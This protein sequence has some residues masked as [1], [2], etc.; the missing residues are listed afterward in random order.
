MLISVFTPCHK[1]NT[2]RLPDLYES[3]KAQ[4]HTDRQWVILLNNWAERECDDPRVKIVK[5]EYEGP[6]AG[7]I[8][9][10][11]FENCKQCDG[12]RFVEVD[13][14]DILT[15]DCLEE[16]AKV[17]EE[18]CFAY[19]NTVNISWPVIKPVTRWNY[20]WRTGRPFKFMDTDVVEMRSAE[21]YP[22][23]ISRIW[24]APNHPRAWRKD[25]YFAIGWHNP[26]MHISDDHDLIQ[27]T[28]I[29]GKLYHIDKPLYIYRIRWDNT[30]Q[31]NAK[32]IQDTMREVHDKFFEP[33]MEKRSKENGLRLIDLWGWLNCKK[34]Y[35]SYDIRDNADIVGD[36]N[37]DRNLADNSVGYMNCSHVLEHLKDRIHSMNEAYRVLAHGW[38][39]QI[40]V[41]SDCWI[42]VKWKYYAP[43]GAT[44]DP[45]HVSYR[46]RR[47]FRYFTEKAMRIFIE[48]DFK[49]MFTI[50]KP[51]KEFLRFDDVPVCRI[52]LM[53]RKPP[54]VNYYGANPWR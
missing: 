50:V 52:T 12:E 37:N 6:A 13:S 30:R 43:Y 42:V 38:I 36:L 40:E 48:P 10:L 26:E 7:Y 29:Y 33:M 19:G 49:G 1:P 16:I 4:T 8:G 21:P 5:D 41:P 14:D 28:Y 17:P 23:S 2:K 15:P 18:Y 54:G 9:R 22:Q 24:F 11:K 53:A 39:M 34:W 31:Q 47:T 20:F 35:E 51:A 3:L 32:K 44:S 27:R 45:G 25:A 46:N